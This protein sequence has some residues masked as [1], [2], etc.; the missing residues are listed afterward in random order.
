MY[1]RRRD[2]HAHSSFFLFLK[3]EG[4]R[5]RDTSADIRAVYSFA[6]TFLPRLGGMMRGLRASRGG[7]T[8][9]TLGGEKK[10]PRR[11]RRRPGAA[12]SRP[13]PPAELATERY[14]S[15]TRIMLFCNGAYGTYPSSYLSIFLGGL[16]SRGELSCRLAEF[17][18]V[19]AARPGAL[20][21]RISGV[22]FSRE[23]EGGSRKGRARVAE[24]AFLLPSR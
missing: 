8:L 2:V 9:G 4:G 5:G 12:P 16:L 22:V 19:R 1:I 10:V 17:A 23:R 11:G 6:V 7:C 13:F 3:G 20:E 15:Q 14:T 21:L 24:S 18:A